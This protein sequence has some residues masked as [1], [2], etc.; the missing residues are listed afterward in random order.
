MTP[1]KLPGCIYRGYVID[2]NT[3][4]GCFCE[5][6]SLAPATL[7]IC[8]DCPFRIVNAF[9]APP[10]APVVT[11]VVDEPTPA[12]EPPTP[13]FGTQLVEGVKGV[14]RAILGVDRA[15]EA[16]IKRRWTICQGGTL[17]DGTVVEKCG[18]YRFWECAKCGCS[19]GLK[20]RDNAQ[21]CPLNPPK[22]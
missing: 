13:G 4:F 14:T 10:V 3:E 18:Y 17:E 22:W 8:L 9:D 2:E 20:I 1:T 21:Q 15:D 6:R 16:T 5:K 19:L 7:Q 12:E 11:V